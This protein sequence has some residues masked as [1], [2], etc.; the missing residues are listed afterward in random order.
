MEG[1]P[2]E[3]TTPRTQTRAERIGIA[4]TSWATKLPPS[5]RFITPEFVGFA[6]LGTFTFLFD[7]AMLAALLHWTALPFQVC[8][9][10]G[11][12]TAF[13]LN[14]VLNRTMNFRSHAPVG[15]QL[16]RYAV[17]MALDFGF[18]LEVTELLH[19]AGLPA[20]V[21]RVATACCVGVFTYVGARFWVFRKE[22]A[23][24]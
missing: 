24:D 11:Y 23:Q 5:L 3:T 6:I 10:L 9:G 12:L 7:M 18:T 22:S 16:L 8:V 2:T 1:V 17:V 14:Y 4:L 15:G 19:E 20:M 21:A 13:G